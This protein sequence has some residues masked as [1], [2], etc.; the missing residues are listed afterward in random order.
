MKILGC[1]KIPC[2]CVA[3]VAVSGQKLHFVNVSREHTGTYQC[4]AT[5]GVDES[6]YRDFRVEVHCEYND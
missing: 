3:D 2:Y 1:R 5:N 4:E 6:D